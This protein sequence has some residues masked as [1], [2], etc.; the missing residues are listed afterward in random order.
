MFSIIAL[1]YSIS[2]F[3]FFI[4]SLYPITSTLA[5]QGR[6]DGWRM[7]P[8]MMS[9]WGIGWFGGVF[10]IVFWIFIIGGLIFMV[11]WLMKTGENG[12]E[13]GEIESRAIE[14]LKERYAKGEI[15]KS[16]FETMRQDLRY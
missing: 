6:Y 5:Q 2:A 9:S 1:R 4:L 7:S 8:G 3:I 11:K 15:D 10:M 12:R 13:D 16:R 14:I